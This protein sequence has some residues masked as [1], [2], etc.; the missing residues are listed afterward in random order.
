MKRCIIDF[1]Q[2]IYQ[3]IQN[4]DIMT[5]LHGRLA[6]F[7][8]R[9]EDLP[10]T[11]TAFWNISKKDK[12]DP[13]VSAEFGPQWLFKTRYIN[14]TLN[15]V[16]EERFSLPVCQVADV[17]TISVRDKEHVGD[18]P[19]GNFSFSCD[20][21]VQGDEIEGWFDMEQNGEAAGKLKMSIQ[22]FPKDEDDR[23]SKEVPDAYFPMREN[24]RLTLYQDADT[25]QLP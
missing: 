22:F 4:I 10:D 24:N 12:T 3:C 5:L 13:F 9:A 15:P 11:D 16:W 25:P 14:N 18:S 23:L 8:D 1:C 7:I 17:I 21:V 20:E 19:V 6:F 2:K